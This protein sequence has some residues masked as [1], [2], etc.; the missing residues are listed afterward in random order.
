MLQA[1]GILAGFGSQTDAIAAGGSVNPNA[2]SALTEAYDGTSWS[3][4][5][6]MATARMEFAPSGSYNTSTGGFVAGGSLQGNP[7]RSDTE[8]WNVET[9]SLNVKDLTQ[10]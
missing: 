4:R 8:E 5:P 3:T 6:S 1:R 9:T 2:N 7:N 10:S